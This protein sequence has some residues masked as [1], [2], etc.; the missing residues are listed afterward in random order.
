M[1]PC[2]VDY[3]V[4]I[5]TRCSFVMEFIEPKFIEGSTCFERHTA[6]HQELCK[7]SLELLMMNGV[8]LETCWAFHKL[9]NSKFYY[10]AASCWYFC[11][12]IK[13]ILNAK[14]NR[15]PA[16]SAVH[17]T[18]RAEV[19][20]DQ[21]S[22]T[23]ELYWLQKTICN[24]GCSSNTLLTHLGEEVSPL[25]WPLFFTQNINCFSRSLSKYKIKLIDPPPHPV[26]FPKLFF[27][28][29]CNRLDGPKNT[30]RI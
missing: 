30:R 17:L 28:S 16:F 2:I 22:L 12:G 3:S 29:A 24:N 20:C 8:P 19:I 5:P 11:W 14:L 25:Q 4:E 26:K 23:T 27:F 18:C 21:M 13:R 15:Q 7:Y 1:D 9:W 6:H 10:K